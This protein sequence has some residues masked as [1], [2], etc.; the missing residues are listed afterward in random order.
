MK[1][2]QTVQTFLG[3]HT[4]KASSLAAFTALLAG[5]FWLVT[6]A[7]SLAGP[8]LCTVCHKRTQTQQYPCNSLEYARHLDHGDPMGS[9]ATPTVTDKS[10]RIDPMPPTPP[11]LLRG[12]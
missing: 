5:A 1:K 4:L 3:R 2:L 12:N 9:C 6:S 8:P 11:V 7:S 10:R